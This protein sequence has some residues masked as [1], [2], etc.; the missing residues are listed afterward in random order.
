MKEDTIC[1]YKKKYIPFMSSESLE[2]NQVIFYHYS[3]FLIF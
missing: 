1:V 2:N 3:A